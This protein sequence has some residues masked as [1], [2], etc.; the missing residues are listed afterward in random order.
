M[1]IE[2]LA[3]D[4]KKELV[5]PFVLTW[6]ETAPESLFWSDRSVFSP[7]LNGLDLYMVLENDKCETTGT[8]DTADS[9]HSNV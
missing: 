9:T 6:A 4:R 2:T 5:R 8:R 1:S 7:S 3:S